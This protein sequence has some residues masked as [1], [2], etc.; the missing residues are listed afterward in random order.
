[1]RSIDQAGELPLAHL[2]GRDRLEPGQPVEHVA[3]KDGRHD[4][5][6]LREGLVG[7]RKPQDLAART[8]R[9][10]TTR[11]WK[12]R[13]ATS[14]DSVPIC[15]VVHPASS[16]DC[17]ERASASR[18]WNTSMCTCSKAAAS[19]A[20]S[21]ARLLSATR[22]IGP[23]ASS[24]LSGPFGNAPYGPLVVAAVASASIT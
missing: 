2:V 17:S 1:A 3:G 23:A 5:A 13:K 16:S 9:P 22:W 18:G 15:V 20:P 7:H 8:L 10:A 21:A 19:R 11:I 6:G 14:C 12:D 24:L 4:M